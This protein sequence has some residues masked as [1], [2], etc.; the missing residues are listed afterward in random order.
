MS[1][2]GEAWGA[3]SSVRAKLMNWLAEVT[4]NQGANL[5]VLL[6]WTY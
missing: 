2:V 4:I 5:R 3:A 1:A 6:C